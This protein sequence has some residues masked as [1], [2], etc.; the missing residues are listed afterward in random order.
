MV[1]NTTR[2]ASHVEQ[3]SKLQ[4]RVNIYDQ[5]IFV[6]SSMLCTFFTCKYE[7]T[8]VELHNNQR[9]SGTG[10][11]KMHKGLPIAHNPALH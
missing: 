6:L 9:Y 3:N 7:P 4:Q 1:K 5:K 2:K 10:M 8:E 11:R